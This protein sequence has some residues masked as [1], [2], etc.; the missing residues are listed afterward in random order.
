VFSVV[1]ETLLRSAPFA[2]GDRLVDVMH[3]DGRTGGGGNSLVPEKIVGWQ[4]QPSVFEE[5]EAC[6]PR[7]FDVTGDAEPERISGLLVSVGLFPMLGV[8]PARGRG[9]V[10]GEGRPGSEHVALISHAIWQR[11][12]GSDP[13]VIGRSITLNDEPYTIVGV[14]ARRFR[15]LRE[16]ESVWLPLDLRGAGPDVAG[17][18]GL[19]RLP[20]GVAV[21]VA[22]QRA[23]VIA[24]QLQRDRPLARTWHVRLIPR[25]VAPVD[26]TTRTALFVLLGAV[27]F[28]LL[29]TCANVANL[30]L[31]QAAARQ[32]EMAIRSAIGASRARLV[33]EVLTDSLV[34]ASAGGVLGVC[35]AVWGVRALIAAAPTSFARM[36]TTTI[37]IDARILAFTAG[38]TF[39]TGI[40]FGIVPA[41]R[42]SRPNLEES[43][44][45]GSQRPLG[46]GAFGRLP[47]AIVVAEVAFSLVL[48]VGAALMMRTLVRLLAIEPGFDP[49]HLLVVHVDIPTD[50]YPNAAARSAF[51]A[52][53]R[54]RL[55][56]VPGVSSSAVA[57]GLPPDLGGIT[58]GVAEAEGSPASGQQ[59]VF[60]NSRVTSDYF[61]TLRIPVIAG[62]T[63]AEDEIDDAMII[64]QAMADHFW[65]NGS[66]VGRRFRL[67]HDKKWRTVVGVVGT[68]EARA[69]REDRSRMQVYYPFPSRAANTVTPPA[70]RG[71]EF[72]WRMLIVRAQDPIAALPAIKAQV[73]ALDKN[74]PLEKP[75]LGK[76]FYAEAFARQRFVLML[77]STFA[78]I[79]L[80]LAAAGI[81]AVLSQTV[82]QRTREIGVRVALGASP[83]DVFRLIMPRG[84][85][86]TLAGVVLGL[87]G[88]SALSRVL[89]SLLF[90]VSPYDP[91]SFGA[92]SALLVA[93]ALVACWLPT[94]RAM[95]VEPAV[96]LRVE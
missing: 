17:L 82:A 21:E 86:L 36:T 80:T 72:E 75:T 4:S 69:F 74:Q 66:A 76:D 48:L 63:F 59:I 51:F 42:G 16:Q 89:T 41:V 71:R 58:W 19:G 57:Q 37:E 52:E 1:D 6:A 43:L 45:G 35:V 23:N 20:A 10:D 49:T 56:V 28:V 70:S 38:L 87:A 44:R 73:W 83:A 3:R 31:S 62:R 33:C 5:F 39:I 2:Y 34:L 9:F 40:L 12:Y 61:Q 47:G 96:A 50:R 18:F 53:L 14:M 65:P 92:V 79:A 78:M 30:F 25:R 64:S 27:G 32:R 7:Q 15:L 26:A 90:E 93:V 60:P 95:C 77:M 94:R 46:G 29:I 24:D 8:Q 84:M 54:R 88:A 68:V 91:G 11:R 13:Q 55:L 81:F 85:T 67:A 22:Q